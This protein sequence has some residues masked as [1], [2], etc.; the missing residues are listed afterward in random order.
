MCY[1]DPLSPFSGL[2]F[3]SARWLEPLAVY[4]RTITIALLEHSHDIRT[5]FQ[6]VLP[7]T[8]LDKPKT[9]I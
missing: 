4:L 5:V 1:C 2:D 8:P 7:T 3:Q 9:V 6:P